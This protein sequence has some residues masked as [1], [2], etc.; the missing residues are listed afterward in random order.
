MKGDARLMKIL[1]GGGKEHL[2]VEINGTIYRLSGELQTTEFSAWATQTAILSQSEK[3]MSMSERTK[4][5]SK[6]QNSSP[7]DFIEWLTNADVQIL[8]NLQEISEKEK[9]QVMQ[10]I[11]DEWTDDKF[12]ICFYDDNYN[13]INQSLNEKK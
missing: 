7:K 12:S 9:N 10:T 6:C 2:D 4:L 11:C 3:A 13:I 8:T 1:H 5:A